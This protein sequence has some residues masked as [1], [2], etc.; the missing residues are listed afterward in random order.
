MAKL[1]GGG[2]LSQKI[3]FQGLAGGLATKFLFLFTEI[4]LN[5]QEILLFFTKQT[6]ISTKIAKH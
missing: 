6:G 2:G 3:V 4:H 1:D 5:L